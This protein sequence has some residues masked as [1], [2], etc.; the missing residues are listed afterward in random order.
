MHSFRL[1]IVYHAGPTRT[2]KIFF[3]KTKKTID[4]QICLLYYVIKINKTV[5]QANKNVL[6]GFKNEI[7][8]FC[9]S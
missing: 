5:C 4:K 2:T 3:K 8:V 6:G 1:I 9:R 7:T